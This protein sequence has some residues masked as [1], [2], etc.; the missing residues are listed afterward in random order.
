[1]KQHNHDN[2]N[3]SNN[4]DDGEGGIGGLALLLYPQVPLPQP[5]GQTGTAFVAGVGRGR[6]G[7]KEDL[8]LSGQ[9]KGLSGDWQ[10]NDY[11]SSESKEHGREW[12]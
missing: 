7:C 12:K 8:A 9:T 11:P 1:M 4:N 2:N 6:S 3:N 5:G 10:E